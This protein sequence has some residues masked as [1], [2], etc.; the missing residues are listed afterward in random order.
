MEKHGSQ[1]MYRQMEQGEESPAIHLVWEVFMECAAPLY[2]KEGI[3]EFKSFIRKQAVKE[4][5]ANGNLFMLAIHG[6]DVVGVIEMRD[7]S[8][9]SLLFVKK[10][11]QVQGIARALLRRAV[12]ICRHRNRQVGKI[13]VNSSPNA[14]DVYVKLG[15][16]GP[17]VEKTVNGL[18]SIRMELDLGLGDSLGGLE[19]YAPV[20]ERC[21]G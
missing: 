11:H 14:Y 17:R 20:C 16:S 7:N 10:T 5:L 18:R 13:T 8:H 2:S 4:R 19:P 15:F 3:D 21:R 1:I 9:I 12:A 6:K